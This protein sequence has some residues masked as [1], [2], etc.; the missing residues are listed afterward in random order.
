[1]EKKSVISFILVL[2]FFYSSIFADEKE[3]KVTDLTPW[4]GYSVSNLELYKGKPGERFFAEVAKYAPKGYT[5]K[6]V[7]DYFYGMFALKFKSFKVVDKDTITIDDNISGDYV[8]VGKLLTKWKDYDLKWEIFKTDSKEMI[9]AGYKYFL[10]MP[11]HQHSQ[12]SL[13]HSHLRYGNQDFDFLTT[14]LSVQS[15]WPTVYQPAVTDEAKIIAA[16][17]KG[18]KLQATMLPP[19]K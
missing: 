11:F 3:F 9:A 4:K 1:M 2:C 18:A 14:D 16:M 17:H 12:D 10:L 5:Q 19:L 6:M 15:W 13:R 8:Y 7:R